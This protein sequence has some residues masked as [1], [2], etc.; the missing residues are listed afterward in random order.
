M[1]GVANGG[2]AR[3]PI[4]DRVKRTVYIAIG[5]YFFRRFQRRAREAGTY[6]VARQLR[7]QGTPLCVARVMLAA[8]P[9]PTLRRKIERSA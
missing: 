1:P 9:V 3:V 5:R 7:K 8:R 4:Q 2:A 6:T